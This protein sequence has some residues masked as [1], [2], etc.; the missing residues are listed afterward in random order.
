MLR[1]V[2]RRLLVSLLLLL[3]LSFIT[4]VVLVNLADPLRSRESG[5]NPLEAGRLRQVLGLDRQIFLGYSSWAFHFLRGNWGVSFRNTPVA[6][7]IRD[8]LANSLVL[9]GSALL[10]SFLAGST[11]GLLSAV[12]QHSRLDRVVTTATLLGLS[13]PGFLLALLLQLFFAITLPRWLHLGGPVFPVTGLMT[14]GVQGFHPL[15]RLWHLALPVAVLSSYF[16]AAFMRFTRTS[17]LEVLQADYIRTAQAKGLHP[18]RLLLWHAMPNALIPVATQLALDI[19][20]IAS[21]F[22][23]IERVFEWP[24]MGTFF[25]VALDRRD[26]PQILPWLTVTAAFI[27][28]FNLL[29]DIV[30]VAL[31]P[32][33]RYR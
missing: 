14:P 25:I 10:V 32:R 1:H 21:G 5:L 16:T 30:Y 24:G 28:A 6:P 20:A 26:W 7:D 12:R 29:A 13:V 31:D 19:G 15:D 17:A 27:I 2:L 23:V 33:I 18:L 11:F 3:L 22:I 9:G 4:Y 8:A